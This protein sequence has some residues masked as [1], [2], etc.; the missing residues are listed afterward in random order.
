[1]K[2]NQLGVDLLKNIKNHEQTLNGKVVPAME[3][4]T[5][6]YFLERA[7]RVWKNITDFPNLTQSK[8]MKELY[9]NIT[10]QKYINQTDKDMIENDKN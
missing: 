3:L 5:L 9:A 6:K 10:M 7:G 1:M 2:C 8:S 4:F